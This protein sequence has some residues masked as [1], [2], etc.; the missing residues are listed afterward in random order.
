MH[1]FDIQQKALLAAA[2]M[3]R[4]ISSSLCFSPDGGR[5]AVGS[6]GRVLFYD[7]TL[8]VGV[9]KTPRLLQK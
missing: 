3:P 9:Q 5:I 7:L 6:E 4:G 2:K 1:L 8:G